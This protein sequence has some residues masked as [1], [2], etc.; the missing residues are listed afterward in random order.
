MQSSAAK[1]SVQN[2]KTYFHTPAG[3]I[4]SVDGVDFELYPNDIL[5]IVGES[6]SGKSVTAQ[7]IMK[8]VPTPPG[9][10]VSGTVRLLDENITELD[11]ASMQNIRGR[12]IGMIF[13]NARASLNPSFTIGYHLI[14]TLNRH[15]HSS[16]SRPRQNTEKE[17]E[18]LLRQ[19]GFAD[20]KRINTSYP[21]Q[22]S[23]GM[24]QR[25]GIAL[26]LAC[27]PEIIIAD[28]PTTALDVIVQAIVLRKLRQIHLERSVPIILIT[29]DFGVARFLANRV[30][31]MYA[32]KIQE[33]GKIEKVL[34]NP[35]HPY[36][37]AL[38][39]SVPDRANCTD[40]LYQI[41]GQSPNLLN[42]PDGCSLAD[43]C[44]H[45]TAYCRIRPPDLLPA[46]DGSMVRCHLYAPTE[47][48]IA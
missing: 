24:C 42:L 37:K 38:I 9:E 23:G 33:Q 18:F 43:R 26:C 39:R 47:M 16:H 31:V 15:S 30:I 7:S 5:A 22:L 19:V 28:E 13:Q 6:G 8:L 34:S 4:K 44:E 17:A 40:R 36:T 27:N 25:I 41:P 14:E 2:L 3:T 1:L 35:A 12:R 48:K 32:G 29:H 45:A 21:H 11:E 20:P 46:P 10:Y